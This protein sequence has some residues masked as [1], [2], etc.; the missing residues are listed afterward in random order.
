MRVS[1]NGVTDRDPQYGDEPLKAYR[2][3]PEVFAHRQ[4][5]TA[6]LCTFHGSSFQDFKVAI[7]RR[8]SQTNSHQ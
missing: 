4:I 2:S 3:T 6:F 5:V 1:M 8:S 7:F